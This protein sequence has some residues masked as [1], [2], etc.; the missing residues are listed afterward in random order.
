MTHTIR[1]AAPLALDPETFATAYD[2][3]NQARAALQSARDASFILTLSA[4]ELA[5]LP[6]S[7]RPRALVAVL[8]ECSR[9][10]ALLATCAD[11]ID[12]AELAG[13][14]DGR[15]GYLAMGEVRAE[16]ARA[17]RLA[18]CPSLTAVRAA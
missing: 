7:E 8:A 5:T 18:S 1:P 10:E 11:L 16:V 3:A 6:R 15:S 9:V 17:R 4:D 2:L 13:G 14:A 12:R